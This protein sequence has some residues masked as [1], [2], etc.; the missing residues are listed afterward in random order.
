MTPL[1]R[2]TTVCAVL[3]ALCIAIDARMARA[4]KWLPAL[5]PN[6]LGW[7]S[8]NAPLPQATLAYMDNPR[9][10][11]R[12]FHAASGADVYVSVIAVNGI[13]SFHDPTVCAEGSGFQQ[14]DV[15]PAPL[16]DKGQA[17]ARALGFQQ[18]AARI[19]MIYWRQDRAGV[20]EADPLP[21]WKSLLSAGAVHPNYQLL[22]GRQECVA[23]VFALVPP[24]DRDG[25][26][27]CRDVL[28]L[29]RAVYEQLQ[30][31]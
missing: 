2:L 5:P 17:T 12:V 11:Q 1:V 6:L 28:G 14:V 30:Q 9:A 25:A 26:A 21:E 27:T 20:V 29:S 4:G 24:A 15:Q 8:T 18:G 13:E 22:L 23:R 31:K 16:D 10:V 19:V 7:T 3:A